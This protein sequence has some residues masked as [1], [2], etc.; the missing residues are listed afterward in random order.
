MAA[1]DSWVERATRRRRSPT[2]LVSQKNTGTV[3]SATTVSCQL[4]TIMATTVDTKMTTLARMLDA[5]VVTTDWTPPTSLASL[6]WISP[7]LVPVKKASG[8]CWR[9][10]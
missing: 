3:T 1:S 6:D 4:S 7:V 9:C 8:S 5:V 2:S 10:E